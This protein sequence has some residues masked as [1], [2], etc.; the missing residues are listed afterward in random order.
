MKFYLASRYDGKLALREIRDK[1]I[2]M[3]HGPCSSWLD[4]REPLDIQV[5]DVGPE[6]L[7]WY[8]LQDVAEILDC[9]TFVHFQNKNRPNI[10]G[11]ALVE[12]G[13]AL[14]NEKKL[15]VVGDRTHI[16]DFMPVVTHFATT[17]EFLAW[18]E[19]ER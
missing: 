16:F 3:G 12:F 9:D 17:G 1:L 13:I 15:I 8:A 14:A 6:L 4:E 19:K 10:R 18:A 2:A 11:G 5:D 7:Q